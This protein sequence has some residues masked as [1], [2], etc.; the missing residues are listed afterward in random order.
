MD[1]VLTLNFSNSF[2][3]FF[4][5]R[6]ARP[7]RFFLANAFRFALALVRW[8]SGRGVRYIENIDIDMTILENIDINMTIL[9]NININKTIFENININIEKAI[10]ENM[11]IEKD[12]KI[13]IFIST[14]WVNKPINSFFQQKV[15]LFMCYDEIWI[16]DVDISTFFG[17]RMKY[18]HL[19]CKYHHQHNID[20]KKLNILI[21]MKIQIKKVWKYWYQYRHR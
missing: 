5:N 17:I 16:T 18:Q 20:K 10:L 9:R 7:S 21:L 6:L 3:W 4:T 2:A 11:D 12:K 14:F 13:L 15:E 19:F 8:G 1:S